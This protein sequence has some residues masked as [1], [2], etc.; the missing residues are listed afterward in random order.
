RTDTL[1]E[2]VMHDI[3]TWLT[4]GAFL[5]AWLLGIFLIVW[6]VIKGG[7]SDGHAKVKIFG[8]DLDLSGRAIIQLVLGA[9]LII[10]PLLVAN[11]VKAQVV[12]PHPV[13][14]VDHIPDPNHQGFTFLHDISVL[15]LRG[16]QAQPLLKHLNFV[17]RAKTNPAT[18][19]NTM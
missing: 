18:L 12:P 16:S 17:T 9:S 13:Q 3:P 2:V 5:L 19:V 6:T 1:P 15:D 8:A 14:T 7:G 4:N 10:L 11:V